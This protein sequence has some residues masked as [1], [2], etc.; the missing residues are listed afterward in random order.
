MERKN[1]AL[2]SAKE[3]C[4]ARIRFLRCDADLEDRDYV[5]RLKA[6]V[7]SVVTRLVI[8]WAWPRWRRLHCAPPDWTGSWSRSWSHWTRWSPWIDPHERGRS[9]WRSSVPCLSPRVVQGR[10]M[11]TWFVLFRSSRHCLCCRDVPPTSSSHRWHG[12]GTQRC[13]WT[14]K[15]CCN[16][17]SAGQAR[18]R[19]ESWTTPAPSRVVPAWIYA[20]WGRGVRWSGPFDCVRCWR[21]SPD[22]WAAVATRRDDVAEGWTCRCRWWWQLTG[23]RARWSSGNVPNW[24]GTSSLAWLD[25]EGSRCWLWTRWLYCC[26]WRRSINCFSAVHTENVW[27]DC[28]R[29]PRTVYA[30]ESGPCGCN[31]AK[32]W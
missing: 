15:S 6:V 24:I 9:F 22:S 3:T 30:G 4:F 14:G 11:W 17:A 31:R 23:E 25:P 27:R 26:C 5:Q 7:W 21:E 12:T 19:A 32:R 28:H 8:S 10:Q 16:P 18:H 20:S 1:P 29:G 13:C 2:L